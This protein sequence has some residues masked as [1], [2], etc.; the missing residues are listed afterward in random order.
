MTM[1]SD[2]VWMSPPAT[3][4]LY[5][6]LASRRY[7]VRF[8]KSCWREMRPRSEVGSFFH[9]PFASRYSSLRERTYGQRM[10]AGERVAARLGN[11]EAGVRVADGGGERDGD[12][13]DGVDERLE[14]T[15]VDL[16][17]V[18][19]ADAEVLVDRVD[20]F[21]WVVTL[22][23]LVDPALAR[24]PGDVDEQVGGGTTTPR[25]ATWRG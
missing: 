8:K 2:T 22:V 21:L 1:Y 12:P 25:P 16:D 17:E 9:S 10:V 11:I 13:V 23:G 7:T 3:S 24:G 5:A 14:C 18:V 20:Q 19:G 15:E 4:G 6:P